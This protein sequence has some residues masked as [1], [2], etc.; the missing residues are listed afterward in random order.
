RTRAMVPIL[1]EAHHGKYRS[2]ISMPG[3]RGG[4]YHP[5][6]AA[7]GGWIQGR[8]YDAHGLEAI[9]DLP[10]KQSF[11]AEIL[12]SLE[13]PGRDLLLALARPAAYIAAALTAPRA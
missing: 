2:S 13:Q 4:G 3:V 8:I 12:G 1:Q 11:H 10:S 9:A 6:L 5:T 7:R